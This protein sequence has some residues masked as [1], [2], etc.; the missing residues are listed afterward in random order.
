MR[1]MFYR[2]HGRMPMMAG[3]ILLSSGVACAT[4]A[5]QPVSSWDAEVV[6]ARQHLAA[7]LGEDAGRLLVKR[8]ERMQWGDTS[9][10]CPVPGRGYLPV[11]TDG[12]QVT[13]VLDKLEYRVNMAGDIV[14]TCERSP[15]ASVRKTGRQTSPAIA[16]Y[17]KASEDL[18]ERLEV[19][20]R[21]VRLVDV[22]SKLWAG[23]DIS[24]ESEE[25]SP[26][27]LAFKGYQLKVASGNQNYIYKCSSDEV[28]Y[29]GVADGD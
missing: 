23:D 17:L 19:N 24:C 12:V 2:L 28:R 6:R 26:G 8:I 10:G 20:R 5:T 9:L 21:T 27:E 1:A 4:E 14:A 11:V 16:L 7:E 15:G 29:C 18:A 3:V 13:F 25:A 22:K